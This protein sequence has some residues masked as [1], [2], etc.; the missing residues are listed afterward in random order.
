MYEVNMNQV[1][2]DKMRSYRKEAEAHRQARLMKEQGQSEGQKRFAG[3]RALF[4]RRKAAPSPQPLQPRVA[5][6]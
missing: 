2:Q 5:T 4:G 6:R 1:A 3:L